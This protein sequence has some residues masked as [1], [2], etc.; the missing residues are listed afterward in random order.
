MQELVI[1]IQYVFN[2]IKDLTNVLLNSTVAKATINLPKALL[3]IN[4]CYPV[5][6]TID[7]I[8]LTTVPEMLEV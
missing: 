1:R 8:K 6:S 5:L 2:W 4:I 7:E 3:W